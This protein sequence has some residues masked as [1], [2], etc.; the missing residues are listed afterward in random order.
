M[1][2]QLY[3]FGAIGAIDIIT[4]NGN[5]LK[6][7]LCDFGGVDMIE[8]VE[9]GALGEEIGNDV[10]DLFEKTEHLKDKVNTK[11]FIIRVIK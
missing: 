2:K 6:V 11:D 7:V 3:T 5:H 4:D 10:A 1:T 8:G 9:D